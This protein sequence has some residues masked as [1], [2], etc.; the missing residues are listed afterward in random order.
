[1]LFLQKKKSA[2]NK[3]PNKHL[4]LL[5]LSVTPFGFEPKTY[6]LEGSCSIQL[7]YG[8]SNFCLTSNVLLVEK[9]KKKGMISHPLSVGVARFELTTSCSQSRR[10]TGLRYTPRKISLFSNMSKFPFP[11]CKDKN[12]FLLCK[13][14]V[15][16]EAR[17]ELAVQL[18]VR[19]F[20]KL[21]VLATHP[22]HL[23]S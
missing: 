5:G 15:A 11:V 20:S 17:F 21:V 3:K 4:D 18:P 10:D 8:A 14:F 13:F 12:F 9:G 22:L 19:Q 2:E 1:M 23:R 6:C 7:S 16:V